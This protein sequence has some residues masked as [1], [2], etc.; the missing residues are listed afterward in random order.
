MADEAD[1]AFDFQ[2]R[3]LS[4]ALA[5]HRKNQAQLAPSGHCHFC[6]HGQDMGRKL[7]CDSA[8]QE[9]WERETEVRRKQ[10][11]PFRG[12]LAPAVAMMAMAAAD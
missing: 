12:S 6:G 4:H 3:H 9:D 5:T 11:L 7:F 2:E 10:G 8:C 1:V